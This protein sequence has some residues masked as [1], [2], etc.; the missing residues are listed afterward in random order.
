MAATHRDLGQQSKDGTFREDL[1]F[2]LNMIPIRIPPLRDRA[3][4]IPEFVESFIN[5]YRK[6]FQQRVD[7]ISDEA[8]NILRDYSWPGN[9]RELEYL[10]ARLVATIRHREILPEDIPIEC[11]LSNLEPSGERSSKDI[12]T[13]ARD[14]FERNFILTRLESEKGSRVRTAER[15]GIPL[16]TLK[17][18]MKKL[19]IY[20]TLKEQ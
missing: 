9:V 13:T 2:R 10:I 1:Y 12:L 5:R 8:M 14:T 11:H 6:K 3:E 7:G 20:A 15:L 18:K 19:G 16:S 17:Y 4:D